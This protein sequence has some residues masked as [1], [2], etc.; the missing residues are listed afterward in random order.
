[1]SEEKN[2]VTPSRMGLGPRGVT[3]IPRHKVRG[4]GRRKGSSECPAQLVRR[5]A[6]E[7]LWLLNEMKHEEKTWFVVRG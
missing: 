1:M 6:D 4:I 2:N 5:P 7:L 3:S